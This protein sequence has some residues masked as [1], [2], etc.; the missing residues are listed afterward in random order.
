M[1][2]VMLMD[3]VP[4]GLPCPERFRKFRNACQGCSRQLDSASRSESHE[5]AEQNIDLLPTESGAVNKLFPLESGVVSNCL[6]APRHGPVQTKFRCGR[7]D[8][9][10]SCLR[11]REDR[12]AEFPENPWLWVRHPTHFA[13]THAPQL[14][15]H[16]F[17]SDSE[18]KSE[19][20]SGYAPAVPLYV[21]LVVVGPGSQVSSHAQALLSPQVDAADY[22]SAER[23]STRNYGAGTCVINGA[24]SRDGSSK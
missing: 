18:V 22:S 23:N 21:V 8:T 20:C 24:C 11:I 15:F 7:G 5:A 2:S 13:D 1:A 19:V 16:R 4:A 17:L 6:A 3:D 10:T 9:D 12:T 14:G